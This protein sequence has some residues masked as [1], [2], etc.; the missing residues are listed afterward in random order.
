MRKT[1]FRKMSKTLAFTYSDLKYWQDAN[2]KC[3]HKDY[4]RNKCGD[5]AHYELCMSSRGWYPREKTPYISTS[6]EPSSRFLY[7]TY[8]WKSLFESLGMPPVDGRVL[9]LLPG[10]ALNVAVGL[11]SL[12]FRGRFDRVELEEGIPDCSTKQYISGVIHGDFFSVL[13]RPLNYD[14]VIGNHI[15]DDLLLF[16]HLRDREAMRRAYIDRCFSSAVWAD[17]A[18]SAAVEEHATNVASHFLRLMESM[19]HGYLILRHYPSTFD[20]RNSDVARID[21]LQSIFHLM[22]W[23][24]RQRLPSSH[25]HS[26]DLDSIPVPLGDRYPS[27]VI[28]CAPVNQEPHQVPQALPRATDKG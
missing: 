10:G 18:A 7:A 21:L 20:L 15:V 19:G 25:V 26:I 28:L 27:S 23:T 11:Q 14:L 4:W 13:E 12:G 3:W 24:L 5:N 9:E 22:T 16:L 8:F 1:H 17:I 2:D 6:A